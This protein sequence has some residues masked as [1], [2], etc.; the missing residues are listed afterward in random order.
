VIRERI[1]PPLVLALAATL[2][3]ALFA[4]AFFAAG[5]GAAD[6]RPKP[7]AGEIRVPAPEPAHLVGL[8]SLGNL[9]PAPTPKPPKKKKKK[10]APKKTPS[11]TR[12]TAP[13]RPPAVITPPPAPPP[14]PPVSRPPPPPDPGCVGA[15]CP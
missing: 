10:K 3:V 2:A 6:K 14:P 9:P 8:R 7:A 4:I 11:A 13:A 5:G 12:P 1:S 15:M